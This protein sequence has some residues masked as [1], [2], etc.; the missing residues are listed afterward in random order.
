MSHLLDRI[1][2]RL[3]PTYHKNDGF[4]V[5]RQLLDE[6]EA[7]I[8]VCR[9][10]RQQIPYAVSR[11]GGVEA[12]VILWSNGFR[13]AG[14]LRLRLGTPFAFTA[15]AAT[16]AG[17]RP[18]NAESYRAFG[19]LALSTLA[20]VDLLSVWLTGYEAAVLSSLSVEPPNYCAGHAH[21]PHLETEPHWMRELVGKKL[22]V[23]SPFAESIDYQATKMERIWEGKRLRWDSQVECYKFPYLLDDDCKLDWRNVLEDVKQVISRGNYDVA[24]FGCGALGQPLATYAKDSGKIGLQLGGYLQLLFGIYGN[25]H[26]DEPDNARWINSHWVRPSAHERPKSFQRVEG[27]CYW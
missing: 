5:A 10:I 9:A 13:F 6:R 17:L 26:A 8:A 20:R 23:V 16:N 25:R 2:R 12:R 7:N 22:L 27:G 19:Q 3:L 1:H 14:P 11:I 24:L 4:W 18:R 15:S 21:G